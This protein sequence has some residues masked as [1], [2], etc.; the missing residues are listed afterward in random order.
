MLS[1]KLQR[2]SRRVLIPVVIL[3]YLILSFFSLHTKNIYHNGLHHLEPYGGGPFDDI[4]KIKCYRWYG[5]CNQIIERSDIEN[6][7]VIWH[8]IDK[9]LDLNGESPNS[10]SLYNEFLYVHIATKKRFNSPGRAIVDIALGDPNSKDPPFYVVNDAQNSRAGRPKSRLD[11]TYNYNNWESR[12]NGIWAKYD[13][14]NSE[15][16]ITNVQYLFGNDI[17]EPRSD[18]TLVNGD[19]NSKAKITVHRGALNDK[20][21][22]ILKK[23]PILTQQNDEFKVLQVSDLHFNSDFGTCKDQINEEIGCKADAKTLNFL[24]QVLDLETPDLVVITGDVIDGANVQDYQTALLKALSPF[25]SRSI[26]FAIALGENDKTQHGSKDDIVKFIMSLP[27]SMMG[28]TD[29][30]QHHNSISGYETNYALKIYDS[31]NDHLQNVIYILD[32]YS[33]SIK[34]SEFLKQTYDSFTEKPKLSLEFQHHPIQEYRPKSAFAIVGAYNEK[35]KL[36]VKTDPK[37]RQTLSEINVQAMSVG[38]EH[39]NEC[40]IHGEDKNN[41]LKSLWLCYGGA[42]GEGGYGNTKAKYERR[43][44]L[45]RMNT[46]NMDIT[47]WKRKQTDPAAVFD[48]QFIHK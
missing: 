37:I 48:Y 30:K 26:P 9:N 2:F 41:K 20:G 23:V 19:L 35:G 6:G 24:H 28:N 39:S 4:K 5:H 42:T 43:V 45:F 38:Y 29:Q 10:W 12:S 47:S 32:M 14:S 31:K 25:I 7:D 22:D 40:C 36:R 46:K 13:K 15:N 44:R 27:F 11:A 3:T 17:I 33:D 18:W 1:Y 8:R 16:A 34:Q 21:G